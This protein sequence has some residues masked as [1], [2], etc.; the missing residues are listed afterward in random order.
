MQVAA[1]TSVL[2]SWQAGGSGTPSTILSNRAA[3]TRSSAAIIIVFIVLEL[4]AGRGV[5]G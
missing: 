3:T 4:R 2:P 1:T 5:S